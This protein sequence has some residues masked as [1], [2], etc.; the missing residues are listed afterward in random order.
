MR[1]A[2]VALLL[3]A[4][5][6]D[7][8]QGSNIQ[9][10]F[11]PAM[12]VQASPYAA[13]PGPGE[14]PANA[15]FTLYAFS[16]GFDEAGNP[17]GH[18]FEL[19]R[20]EIH[21]IVDLQSPCFIDVGDRVP[22]PGLH[23]SQYADTVQAQAGADDIDV[24]TAMQRQLNVSALASEMGPKVV[25]SASPGS[26][27]PIAA[28]CTD[29]SGFPPASC[30]DAESNRRRL[31]MCNSAWRAD[32]AYFEGTDRILTAPLNGTTH[33]MVTGMNP[34]N[35]APIGGAQFFVDEALDDAGGFAIYT[36]TDDAPADT[37]GELLLFGRPEAATRGVIHVPMTSL[38]SP[39]VTA[40][41]AIFANI[42][43]DDVH[44]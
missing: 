14:L 21:R 10:D 11:S 34:V 20:F 22:F 3:L 4:G 8:L 27:G 30:T 5:C 32:E 28:D 12:P 19:Q 6:I 15:H 44:F 37:L 39:S 43:E 2:A 38:V 25:S 40:T 41:L 7:E 35:L 18:L 1:N 17:V 9:V 29:T 33:G 23:V 26:Y 13:A 24:G 42:H 31:D 16:D 36:K